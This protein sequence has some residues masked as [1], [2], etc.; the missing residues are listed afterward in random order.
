MA[1]KWPTQSNPTDFSRGKFSLK[2]DGRAGEACTEGGLNTGAISTEPAFPRV[3]G[4]ISGLCLIVWFDRGGGA[5]FG[6]TA[7]GMW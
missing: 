6:V 2:V 4:K 7:A 5:G 3:V 1:A